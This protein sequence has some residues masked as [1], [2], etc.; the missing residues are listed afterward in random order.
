MAGRVPPM[1]AVAGSRLTRGYK[2]EIDQWRQMDGSVPIKLET[3][4]FSSGR[5]K[6]SASAQ[7]PMMTSSR[8]YHFSGF[9]L[10][11]TVWS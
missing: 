7:R 11:L 8:A 6:I 2:N 9:A 5:I 3:K 1:A 10:L 4:R